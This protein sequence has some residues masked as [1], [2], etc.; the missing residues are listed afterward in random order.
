MVLDAVRTFGP[1]PTRPSSI[2]EYSS[3]SRNILHSNF[4][5]NKLKTQRLASTVHLEQTC[6]S[7]FQFLLVHD[8]NALYSMAGGFFHESRYLVS[9]ENI[10]FPTT[11]VD[12]ITLPL[13]I[14][15]ISSYSCNHA[16]LL[17]SMKLSFNIWF[18]EFLTASGWEGGIQLHLNMANLWGGTKGKRIGLNLLWLTVCGRRTLNQAVVLYKMLCVYMYMCVFLPACLSVCL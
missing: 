1:Q 6:T 5:I 10:V 18:N 13:F 14:H 12:H 2:W 11:D 17:G 8:K 16:L 15:I 4:T 3:Q 7:S 9:W